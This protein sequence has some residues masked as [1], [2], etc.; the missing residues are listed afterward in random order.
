MVFFGI[1]DVCIRIPCYYVLVYLGVVHV[2]I[3]IEFKPFRCFGIEIES[4]GEK[5]REREIEK[6][7]G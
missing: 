2:R 4:K 7:V 6:R 5:E 1:H 3:L